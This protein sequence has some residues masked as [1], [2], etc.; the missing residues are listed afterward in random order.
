MKTSNGMKDIILLP[1]YNERE[2]V[3]IIIPEIF[4]SY[5]EINILVI[6]DNSPDG[7]VE[8]VEKLMF[9]Y[10]NLSVL[11]RKGK[12][13]L[14]KAYVDAMQRVREDKEVRA[15]I[16]MDA[17]GSHGVKYLKDLLREIEDYDLVIGSR[18][19]KDGGVENWELW[20]KALSKY[21]NLYAKFLA[22][23]KIRD[24]T[25][26]FTCARRELLERIDFDQIGSSGYAFLMELK[27]YFV[28]T[29][30]AKVKEVPI[31]FFQRREGKTKFSRRILF[32]GLR[33]PWKL[34]FKRFGHHKDLN[35]GKKSWEKCWE[36]QYSTINIINFGR[37]IYNFFLFKFLKKFINKQ[38]DFLELGCGTA[39]LGLRLAKEA[40]SYTGFD[41]AP[42]ILEKARASFIKNNIKNFILKE[43]D[44]F[45][46]S[47][48][49]KKYDLVW[50][51][52]L[53]EHFENTEKL[54]DIHLRLCE[55]GGR[56]IISVPAKYSY[57]HLWYILTR[58]GPLKKF[59]P[60]TDC[61]FI[62]K[63]YF[64]EKMGLIKNEFS[65]YEIVYLKPKILGLTVLIIRK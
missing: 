2:N 21:G 64:Q 38:T 7:T 10:Q 16:T 5:P 65:Q 54:I 19:I 13:G 33:A 20:R 18:Y 61:I 52:G 12:E 26:G 44:I 62:S 1:T 37:Q 36:K 42:N 4:A 45:A 63:K 34:F 41:I 32:E 47:E 56:V 31:I 29:L 39:S 11:K 14:G 60:W 35:A 48:E 9:R 15:V 46:L 58:L 30:N 28:K 22:G 40:N 53:I 49:E 51:Q 50:S 43:K 8:E 23:L 57:H 17:D 6:D 27:F 24:I 55:K 59:W 3:K 25:A